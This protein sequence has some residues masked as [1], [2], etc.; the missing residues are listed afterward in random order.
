[1][2]EDDAPPVRHPIHHRPHGSRSPM[3]DARL[4]PPRLGR[5]HRRLRRLPLRRPL[6]YKN[7]FNASL[8]VEVFLLSDLLRELGL[9]TEA[10]VTLAYLLGSN[11]TA[12]LEGVGP[13]LA[14][15]MELVRGF[16]GERGLERFGEWWGKVQRGE[17][18]EEDTKTPFRRRFVSPR[19]SIPISLQCRKLKK[20]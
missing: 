2:V 10:L 11:Y 4:P 16:P 17:D 18:T 7:I 1:M 3:R 6:D 12:G 13:V 14:M 9:D 8:T 5:H 15:A 20:H 19:F